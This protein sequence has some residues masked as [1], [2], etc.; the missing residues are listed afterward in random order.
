MQPAGVVS[1]SSTLQFATEA[2]EAIAEESVVSLEE[3]HKEEA[4]A[5]MVVSEAFK[6]AEVNHFQVEE[7][8][9]VCIFFE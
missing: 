9:R 3:K 8:E 2:E 5:S 1:S 7:P 6:V 4:I